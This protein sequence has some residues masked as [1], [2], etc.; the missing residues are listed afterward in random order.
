MKRLVIPSLVVIILFLGWIIYNQPQVI[1]KDN[2][3]MTIEPS[4]ITI[5]W[6]ENGLHRQIWLKDHWD[7][8]IDKFSLTRLD[9]RRDGY[10]DWRG[11][12]GYW[13]SKTTVNSN[14]WKNK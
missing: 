14:P 11:D 1:K 2:V 3:T 4:E 5:V 8:G 13:D 12:E 9:E 10:V 7:F 6:I